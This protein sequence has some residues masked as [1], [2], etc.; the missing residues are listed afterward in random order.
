MRPAAGS[1]WTLPLSAFWLGTEVL[2]RTVE[3]MGAAAG[4]GVDEMVSRGVRGLADLAAPGRLVRMEPPPVA[5]GPAAR[6]PAG[7]AGASPAAAAASPASGADASP[8]GAA[9]QSSGDTAGE[10][11]RRSPC[12]GCG[13]A[14]PSSGSAP[15]P[16]GRE[17]PCQGC[18][19]G[20][21]GDAVE[22]LGPLGPVLLL[23][24]LAPLAPIVPIVPV[25]APMLLALAPMAVLA[26][27]GADAAWRAAVAA[28][29]WA[30]GGDRHAGD[31]GDGGDAGWE[32]LPPASG[33]EGG[34]DAAADRHP[35]EVEGEGDDLR[36]DRVK[37]VRYTLLSLRPEEERIL[38]RGETLVT[39]S[40]PGSAFAAWVISQYLDA[41]PL[42]PGEGR[43]LRV[44]RQVAA[45]YDRR[46]FEFPQRQVAALEEIR[47]ALLAAP[48]R[49]AAPALPAPA[50]P[51]VPAALSPPADR[52]AEKADKDE[53]HG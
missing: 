22:A 28:F 18:R 11:R 6:G 9:A 44:H 43:Y 10:S 5:A 15:R 21:L 47:D 1:P 8:A 3:A 38:R 27:A 52:T 42:P 36:D 20:S 2:A 7:A 33:G 31:T 32:L 26:A 53:D 29:E 13:D 4:Q 25:A 35:G 51:A 41:H 24:P 39:E 46:P 17:A 50:V 12:A 14:P 19:G 30:V 49:A 48:P 23:A 16:G 45:R 37:L 40:L 34:A